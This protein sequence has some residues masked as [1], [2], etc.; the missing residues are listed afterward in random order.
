MI[1]EP[2]LLQVPADAV[3]QQLVGR[4][5][6]PALPVP[7]RH[8]AGVHRANLHEGLHSRPRHQHHTFSLYMHKTGT[9][10]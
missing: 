7:H 4:G 6:P 10:R 5:A 3:V 2:L 1:R 8:P 9:H